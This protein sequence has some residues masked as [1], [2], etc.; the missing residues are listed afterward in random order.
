[1]KLDFISMSGEVLFTKR[2]AGS[3]IN[4]GF[5]EDLISSLSSSLKLESTNIAPTCII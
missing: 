3:G 1:M 2:A 5:N 4:P